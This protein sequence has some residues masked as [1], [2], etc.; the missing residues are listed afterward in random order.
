[1]PFD[2][3]NNFL[4]GDVA[5]P[6]NS[7]TVYTPLLTNLHL[8]Y[9]NVKMESI[10]VDG[11]VLPIEQVCDEGRG[12]GDA[13]QVRMPHS[14]PSCGSRRDCSVLLH[15]AFWR[16]AGVRS[17]PPAAPFTHA[18]CCTSTHDLRTLVAPPLAERLRPACRWPAGRQPAQHTGLPPFANG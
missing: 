2:D 8:H 6:N 12:R 9:Y 14:A 4:T 7:T 15:S 18:F 3:A 10:T 1:M 17:A 5:L 16:A 11:T 13:V